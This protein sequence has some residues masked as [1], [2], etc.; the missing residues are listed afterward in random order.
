M[1]FVSTS[2]ELWRFF[3]ADAQSA[4]AGPQTLADIRSYILASEGMSTTRCVLIGLDGLSHRH[5]ERLFGAHKRVRLSPMLSTVPTTSSTAWTTIM[6]GA[7]PSRHGV[8]GAAQYMP[9]QK[10]SVFF[11]DTRLRAAGIVDRYDISPARETII[12]DWVQRGWDAHCLGFPAELDGNALIG[13]W[14]DQAQCRWL[15]GS[16]EERFSNPVKLAREV[17][18]QAGELLESSH[19]FVFAYLN[20]DWYIHDHGVDVAVDQAV[21]ESVEWAARFANR[22][23]A[24]AFLISDHGMRHQ[25]PSEHSLLTDE[26]LLDLCRCPV[27]GGG[28]I[29]YVYPKGSQIDAARARLVAAV[30]ADGIVMTRK[31]FIDAYHASPLLEPERIGEL[32]VVSGDGRFPGAMPDSPFEHG[33]VSREEM[34]AFFAELV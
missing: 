19:S 2:D 10:T 11:F 3:Q 32:V 16:P 4:L 6:T 7:P 26:A 21:R 5:A 25:P 28:R 34:L 33:G 29:I 15:S 24:K 20:V 17:L 31:E 13:L 22:S 1:K 30:G 8:Y 9:A 14:T 27:G 23:G 18:E 12:S